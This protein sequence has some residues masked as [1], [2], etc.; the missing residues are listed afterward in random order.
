MIYLLSQILDRAADEAPEQVAF[1]CEQQTLTYGE[2]LQR[3]NGLAQWLVAHG[4]ARGDRVGIYLNKSLESAIAIYGIWKAGAAYVPLDP[5]AP[6]SRLAYMVNHCGIRHLIT[7]RSKRRKLPALLQS[8]P[9][10][11]W[12]VGIPESVDLKLS[13]ERQIVRSDWSAVPGSKAAPVVKLLSQ[14]LAYIMYTSGSTGAP[15]GM[16][17]THDSGLSYAQLAARTYR[18]KASDRIG[19][20]S[21][22][23]FDISTL[24]F[25]AGPLVKATTI[26]IPEAYT[27]L[28]A[29]L[30]QLIQDEALTVWY[31]VPFALTQLILRGVL[32]Q[33]DLS[34]LRWVLFAGE[35]FPAKYLYAL[36]Q[37]L[38]NARFSNIYGPAEVNQCMYYHVPPP[39][40]GAP[41]PKD[42]API[43]QVWENSEE[44]VVDEQDQP[45]APGEMGE[46]LIRSATMMSGYWQQPALNAKAFFHTQI[47]NQAAVFYRTGD[48]VQQQPDG[49]YRFIGR[50]DRQI[51]TRG[52]RVELDE[53]E[54][55]LVNHPDVEEAATYA[56]PYEAGSYQIEA[57]VLLKP[58]KA[59]GEAAL[60]RSLSSHLP[61]YA[62]PQR[63]SIL[64]EFPRTGTGKID[65]RALQ[66]TALKEPAPTSG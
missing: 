7:H 61:A 20:H 47:A 66:Q 10:L 24:G 19:N 1:R 52:Y 29:S 57:A 28:P 31:S 16:M 42:I 37:Q 54:T 32:A 9:A 39:A 43:G 15:K 27:K 3:A 12:I 56:V 5:S 38:P 17:H 55:T 18:L 51:K 11:R 22:L 2:L 48:L 46:L 41:V 53:V 50:K 33:R 34:T 26:I 14:D 62:I 44:L 59:V 36:M 60:M 25:F 23:H 58:E 65:R 4:V 21:P 49:Q 45:V 8:A 40:A 13:A 30:S 63:I 35:P 64:K 6:I